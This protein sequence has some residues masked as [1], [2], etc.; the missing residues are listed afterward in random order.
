MN[1]EWVNIWQEAIVARLGVLVPR[2][3]ESHNL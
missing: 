3:W 1:G 2:Q